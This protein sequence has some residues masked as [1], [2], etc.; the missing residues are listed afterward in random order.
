M[1]HALFESDPGGLNNVN[2]FGYD[3]L[4]DLKILNSSSNSFLNFASGVSMSGITY[5]GNQ[6]HALYESDPG[7]LNNVN[8]F[9][10]DS[11]ADLKALNA[12]S[13]SFLNFASGVSM[14]GL[15]FDGNQYHALFES[16]PGGLNNV[17]LFSYDSFAD[18][19]AL[20]ASSS[21][22]L[23]F[24][25]G[26]SMSGLSFDGNQ[27]H[28]LFESDPGGLNN[29]NLFS[30]DSLADLKALNASSSSSL[31]FASGV[32]MSGLTFD[33]QYLVT[34]PEPNSL[35]LLTLGLLTAIRGK[36]SKP[37]E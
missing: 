26:V 33:N 10:Y 11:L 8:L 20:N 27:Y 31:N 6:Y 37:V 25:S 36:K 30:Y 7:G 3:S 12:S 16:D 2:L 5:D 15:T 18:L 1:F 23:N 28:A 24:A 14:S 9:S 13:S 4:A 34:I 29:V 32:S 19:K 17:N 21:S 22:F 35:I